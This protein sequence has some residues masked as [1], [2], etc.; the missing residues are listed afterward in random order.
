MDLIMAKGFASFFSS[1][2]YQAA[3]NAKSADAR[4][5]QSLIYR[6]AIADSTIKTR[7]KVID[8]YGQYLS[9]K[10]DKST[11]DEKTQELF[12][13]TA[14]PY[15]KDVLNA[16]NYSASQIAKSDATRFVQYRE[17]ARRAISAEIRG[18]IGSLTGRMQA[19]E[20]LKNGV[21]AYSDKWHNALAHIISGMNVSIQTIKGNITATLSALP[22]GQIDTASIVAQ[23]RQSVA[24]FKLTIQQ[25]SNLV[26]GVYAELA[27]LGVVGN[28]YSDYIKFTKEQ[29]AQMPVTEEDAGN[30]FD[31]KIANGDANAKWGNKNRA[32][33]IK[34]VTKSQDLRAKKER[35]IIRGGIARG[36]AISMKRNVDNTLK[37]LGVQNGGASN[38]TDNNNTDNNKNGYTVNDDAKKQKDYANTYDRSVARPTQVIINIDKLANFDRTAISKESNERTIAEVIE[39]KIAEAV[40]MLSAQILTTASATISQ[41]L[42]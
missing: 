21:T 29:I 1:D 41:G 24:G 25:F 39:T 14:T 17:A 5:R 20:D 30:W 23:V 42:S 15:G 2:K 13:M 37:Q 22:N 35:N 31:S 26:T 9:K 27:K 34:Y 33:Y 3:D 18:D 38:A 16:D 10:I 6:G 32:E 36:T 11:Y 7:Q 40:S 4:A 28:N 8:L 19:A 12:N